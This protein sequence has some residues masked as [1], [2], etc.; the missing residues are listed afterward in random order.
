MTITQI[1]DIEGLLDA[2]PYGQ[3]TSMY[4]LG[5]CHQ[6][7]NQPIALDGCTDPSASLL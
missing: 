3:I 1:N 5:I 4:I 6:L 7:K 2:L